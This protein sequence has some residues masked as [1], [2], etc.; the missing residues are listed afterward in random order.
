MTIEVMN[1]NNNVSSR[2][3]TSVHKEL[4]LWYEFVLINNSI[5]MTD[6]QSY[7][8]TVNSLIILLS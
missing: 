5:Q 6:G 7:G 2:T 4:N 8:R 3:T 1:N